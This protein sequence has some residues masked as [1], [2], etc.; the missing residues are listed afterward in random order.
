M[1]KKINI[2]GITS[3]YNIAHVTDVLNE[4]SGVRCVWI[5]LEEKNAIVKLDFNVDDNKFSTA[6]NHAGYKT[7]RVKSI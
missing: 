6:L 3:S 5:N 2:D 4:I 7:L 1:K